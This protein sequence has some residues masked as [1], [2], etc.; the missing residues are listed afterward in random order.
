M[1][2]QALGQHCISTECANCVRVCVVGLLLASAI[3]AQ[4]ACAGPVTCA[5]RCA[6]CLQK[7]VSLLKSWDDE[8]DVIVFASDAPNRRVGATVAAG[9]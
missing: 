8:E 6:L 2:G 1:L 9:P 3:T 7:H 5:D 4:V